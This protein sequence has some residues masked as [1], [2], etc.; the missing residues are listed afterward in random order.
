MSPSGVVVWDC[1]T[2]GLSR[3]ENEILSISA[4]CGTKRF[5][6]FI[7]PTKPIPPE[8]SR[9]NKLYAEDL[10]G[11]PDYE[12]AALTFMRWVRSTAGPCPLLVAYNGDS[13]DLPFLLYK[14]AAIAPDKFPAFETIYT[15]DPLRCAQKAFTREQV[16]GSFRQASVYKFLFGAEPPQEEQHTSQGDVDAL[17]RI[18][19]HPQLATLVTASAKELHD[20]TGQFMLSLRAAKAAR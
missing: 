4:A 14:N 13:F 18:V 9:I 10:A 20:I 11:A 3:E 19:K 17:N 5:N 6:I 1:E 15:A 2:S 12:Q 7:R 16:A 8:A